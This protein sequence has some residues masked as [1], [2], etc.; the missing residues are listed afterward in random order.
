MCGMLRRL[1]RGGALQTEEHAS[2]TG[3]A[4]DQ[5]RAVQEAVAAGGVHPDC[6]VPRPA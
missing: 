4:E 1:K 2:D 5:L 3:S 6:P